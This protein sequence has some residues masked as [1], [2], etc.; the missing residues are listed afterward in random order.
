MIV[1][2]LPELVRAGF[3]YLE[4]AVPRGAPHELP[5]PSG[6]RGAALGPAL[7]AYWQVQTTT[8]T[9]ALASS[10][11]PRA[12]VGGLGT[13]LGANKASQREKGSER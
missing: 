11:R 3:Y 10:L 2:S 5:S 4:A 6:E 9:P 8:K 13:A 7:G 12:K 1:T